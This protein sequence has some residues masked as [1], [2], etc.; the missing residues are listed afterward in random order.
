MTINCAMAGLALLVAGAACAQ[1]PVAPQFE[2]A[3]VKLSDGEQLRGPSG[4][5]SGHGRLTMSNVTLKR[6]IMGAW[7][8]GPNQIAG[9]PDWLDT[10]SYEIVAR[11][12]RP[13][14]DEAAINAMLKSLL[15][16]RFKL[17]VHPET[18]TIQAYVLEVANTNKGPKLEK[19]DAGE[20]TTGNGRGRI[21]ATRITMDRFAE[22]LSRQ[23]DLPVVNHTGLD[24]SFNLKLAWTPQRLRV[25]S[26]GPDGSVP[27]I[28]T[29][30]QE[31]L[32]LRLRSAKTSIGMLVIDHAER[33]SEN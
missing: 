11:A 6:C 17:E 18:R 28:F 15:A 26:A 9:G 13:I 12:E 16:D 19:A 8:L 32:G 27:T 7:G 20:S 10:E 3:S 23:M 30:I 22:V 31:Q 25:D 33:P 29:A 24:G 2:V 5:K 21:D 14:N 1:T 4:G